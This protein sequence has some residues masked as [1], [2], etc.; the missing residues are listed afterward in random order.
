DLFLVND[1]EQPERNRDEAWLF[2]AKLSVSGIGDDAPFVGRSAAL[3]NAGAWDP[4]ERSLEL[5][6]R[7]RIEFAVG[8]NVAVHVHP[9]PADPGRAERVET[10]CAP[11]FE[12]ARVD[13]PVLPDVELD[14]KVL[15]GLTGKEL[16]QRLAPLADQYDAWLDGEERRIDEPGARVG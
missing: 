15:A 2:Q 5:L 13:A 16:V 11:R 6:Y 4:E 9:A 1:Q 7:N 14:M 3:G 12:V 8:H 10:D